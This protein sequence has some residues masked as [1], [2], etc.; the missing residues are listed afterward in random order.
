[1]QRS[2]TYVLSKVRSGLKVAG[3][4]LAVENP[5]GAALAFAAKSSLVTL[6]QPQGGSAPVVGR[7]TYSKEKETRVYGRQDSSWAKSTDA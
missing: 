5:F 4:D 2:D 7:R 3:A 6:R 1:M